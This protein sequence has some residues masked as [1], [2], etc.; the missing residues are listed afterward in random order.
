MTGS[1]VPFSFENN[2]TERDSSGFWRGVGKPVFRSTLHPS[3]CFVE[4]LEPA[5][6]AYVR[7]DGYLVYCIE[8]ARQR[9]EHLTGFS[10]EDSEVIVIQ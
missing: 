1:G 2:L 7:G 8:S 3:V 4:S 6:M 5:E 9:V 10:L